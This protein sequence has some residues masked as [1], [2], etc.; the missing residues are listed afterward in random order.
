[1]NT[2]RKTTI[3]LLSGL[4]IGTSLVS[5]SYNPEPI[6]SL[7]PLP[8]VTLP[9]EPSSSSSPTESAKTDYTLSEKD[10]ATMRASLAD[11]QAKLGVDLNSLVDQ[12]EGKPIYFRTNPKNDFIQIKFNREDFNVN[13][14]NEWLKEQNLSPEWVDFIPTEVEQIWGFPEG[15]P[16]KESPT[17]GFAYLNEGSNNYPTIVVWLE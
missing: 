12:G 6:P 1:M 13:I 14:Y 11:V 8:S 17:G 10:T 3:I 4:V 9:S 15:T 5:C 16:G 2:I 7:T